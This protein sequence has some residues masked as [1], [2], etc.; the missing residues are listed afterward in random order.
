[1]A[2]RTASGERAKSTGLPSHAFGRS[3]STNL[4]HGRPKNTSSARV[5]AT[6]FGKNRAVKDL[7]S[8]SAQMDQSGPSSKKSTTNKLTPGSKDGLAKRGSFRKKQPTAFPSTPKAILGLLKKT[9]EFSVT[10]MVN[11]NQWLEKPAM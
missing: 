5:S 2:G 8:V 7:T 6:L 9:A 1:M 11:L 3:G 10:K 4:Q